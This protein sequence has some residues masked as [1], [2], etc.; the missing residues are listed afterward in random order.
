MPEKLISNFYYFFAV[1]VVVFRVML[2][3]CTFSSGLSSRYFFHN[4]FHA[5]GNCSEL[6]E[7]FCRGRHLFTDGCND[8]ICVGRNQAIVTRYPWCSS[9]KASKKDCSIVLKQA[10]EARLSVWFKD[11]CMIVTPCEWSPVGP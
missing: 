1:M 9:G 5:R 8:Y 4:F 10:V 3:F 2:F 11:D 6:T 7:A